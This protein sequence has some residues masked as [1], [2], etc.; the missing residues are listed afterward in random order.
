[1]ANEI[2]DVEFTKS[3]NSFLASQGYTNIMSFGVDDSD[4]VPGT[5]D[6]AVYWLEPLKPGDSRMQ[7]SDDDYLVEDILSSDVLEMA[8]GQDNTIFM[9]KVPAEDMKLYESDH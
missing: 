6:K 5:D 7:D 1:M 9:I 3:L 4:S 8:D 2:M